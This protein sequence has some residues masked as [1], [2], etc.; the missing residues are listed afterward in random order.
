MPSRKKRARRRNRG[1]G[2]LPALIIIFT[3]IAAL[4][5]VLLIQS[6]PFAEKTEENTPVVYAKNPNFVE[7]K[8]MTVAPLVVAAETPAAQATEEPAAEPETTPQPEAESAENKEALNR[9]CPEAQE[10]EYFLPVFDR[11]DRT[12]DDEMMIAI[13][14]DNCNKPESMSK[15]IKTARV[16]DAK[17]TLFPTGEALSDKKMTAS[18]VSCVKDLGYEIENYSY[19]KKTEYN[20]S[21]GEMALQLWKQNITLSYILGADYE[22]HF[23]RPVKIDSAG[24]QR[25]HYLLAQMGLYGIGGYTCNYDGQT[26]DTL[27]KTLKNGNIYRFDMTDKALNLYKEFIEYACS[28]GYKCVTMNKLF[29][30]NEKVLSKN[31]TLDQQTLPS[32][33]G[34]QPSYYDLVVNSRS[35]AVF[36]LQTR[37]SALGYLKPEPGEKNYVPDGLYGSDTSRAVSAFQ[38]RVGIAAT[39]N[40]D[41]KTQQAL[42]SADAPAAY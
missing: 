36:S 17:L 41:I 38:S 16:Y 35:Y 32:M 7:Q 2:I 34:Y 40:A 25:T 22:Q 31:L 5:I 29:G 33:D 8:N 9:F 18:F 20:L 12:P 3:L 14:L 24:D 39:G 37:L 13:T 27:K 15:Y 4:L 1:S 28:K 11:A 23:F 26:I 42:F 19:N 30:L 21:A 10:G 6:D